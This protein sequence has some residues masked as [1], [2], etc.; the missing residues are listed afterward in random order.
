MRSIKLIILALV[1][2]GLP[3]LGLT[4]EAAHDTAN[5]AAAHAE[6]GLT[7]KAVEIWHVFGFPITNS[8][9]ITWVVALGLIIFA[10]LATRR[11]KYVP[12]GAQNF[13]E[14]LVEGLY[15]FLE[16][17]IGNTLVRKTFWFFATIFIFILFCNW[18]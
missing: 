12:D 6:H 18:M 2:A 9:L 11:M 4:A 3:M 17:I 5:A 1:L 15:N 13:L 14:W 16:G 8:M 7:S 10:Q